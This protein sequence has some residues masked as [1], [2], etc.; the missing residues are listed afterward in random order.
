MQPLLT[1]NGLPF[2]SR[3]CC[4]DW[5]RLESSIE[6]ISHNG[7]SRPTRLAVKKSGSAVV[8]KAAVVN[9]CSPKAS[10]LNL[11]A[12]IRAI[13]ASSSKLTSRAKSWMVSAGKAREEDMLSGKIKLFWGTVA[14]LPRQMAST[15][16]CRLRCISC[17][18]PHCHPLMHMANAVRLS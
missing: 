2:S 1:R 10:C 3:A 9:S 16:R 8:T 11:N 18:T 13:P 12:R 14:A 5:R 4:M 17:S 15:L 6:H 7:S